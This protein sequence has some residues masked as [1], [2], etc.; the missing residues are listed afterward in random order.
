MDKKIPITPFEVIKR[1]PNI[2]ETMEWSRRKH[3]TVSGPEFWGT[4]H[5]YIDNSLKHIIFC[6]K[7]DLTTQV[8]IGIPTG[9]KEWRKYDKDVNLLLSKRLNDDSLEW[10]IYKDLVLYKGKMLP[11]KD[12]SEEPYWGEIIEVEIFNDDVNDQWVVLKIK[13]LYS[14]YE[15]VDAEIEKFKSKIKDYKDDLFGIT[16]FY[17]ATKLLQPSSVLEAVNFNKHYKN[18]M[19]RGKTIIGKAEEALREVKISHNTDRFREIIFPPLTK[20]MPPIIDTIPRTKLLIETY[21][22]LFPGRDRKILLTNQDILLI[23]NR[24]IKKF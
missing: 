16:L 1:I 11:P 5:I 24:V 3:L 12:I 15:T 8:F 22:E 10:K 17:Q 4:H 6:L 14:K 20:D 23:M 13:E 21:D 2:P 19:N 18:I 7:E 9:A